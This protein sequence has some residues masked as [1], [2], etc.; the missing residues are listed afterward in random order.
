MKTNTRIQNPLTVIAIFAG[1]AETAGTIVLIGLPIEIQ[2]V[3]VWFVM[4]L[5]V[6]LI[7]SFFMVL[8]FRHRV[9]YAPSDFS[10]EQYFMDLHESKQKLSEVAKA[11]EESKNIDSMPES[12]ALGEL[13]KKMD[14]IAS[15][16][17]SEPQDF[18][19]DYLLAVEQG[20]R[21][22]RVR[23]EIKDALK[24]KPKGMSSNEIFKVTSA[25][26][27]AYFQLQLNA[28]VQ[29]GVVMRVNDTYL[30]GPNLLGTISQ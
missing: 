4:L 27:M 23:D 26:S 15:T 3:F 24:R 14:K 21:I 5:P 18:S 25:S 10:N 8:I 11:I 12:E 29:N 6:L 17:H 30:P 16:V 7:V 1:L 19:Y 2:R 22:V 13:K 28:L 9:L 20:N